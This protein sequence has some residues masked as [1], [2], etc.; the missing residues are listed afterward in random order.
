MI[1]GWYPLDDLPFNRMYEADRHWL[2]KVLDGERLCANVLY[3]G[4]ARGFN[5]IE[6]FPLA[7]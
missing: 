1:P 3:F 7:I 2:P 6:P 4:R 5:R